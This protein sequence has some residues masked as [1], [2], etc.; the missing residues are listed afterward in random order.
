MAVEQIFM[1][2]AYWRSERR[3]KARARDGRTVEKGATRPVCL[4]TSIPTRCGYPPFIETRCSVEGTMLNK[5]NIITGAMVLALAGATFAATPAAAWTRY[6]NNNAGA[7]AGAAI[8]GMAVGAAIGAATSQ[9]RY[10]GGYGNGYP[11]S[12]YGYGYEP[13][14]GYGYDY[15]Y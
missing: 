4:R 7:V 1:R 13:A 15:G 2:L 12:A 14:Y 5:T 3:F 10:Y 9:N 11:P 8:A 6:R